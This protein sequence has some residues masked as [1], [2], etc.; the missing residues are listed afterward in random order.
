MPGRRASSRA[1]PESLIS[2]VVL[3]N[4]RISSATGFKIQ[5][6]KGIRLKNVQVTPKEGPP[7]ILENAQVEGLEKADEKK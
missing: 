7:F 3:E 5:N 6:A 2:N 4:V 1:F